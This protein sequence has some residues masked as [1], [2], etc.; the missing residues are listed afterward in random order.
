[1][2]WTAPQLPLGTGSTGI[3]CGQQPNAERGGT[4]WSTEDV[5]DREEGEWEEEPRDMEGCDEGGGGEEGRKIEGGEVGKNRQVGGCDVFFRMGDAGNAYLRS[6]LEAL[7]KQVL[8]T[9]ALD[10]VLV[11][12]CLCGLRRFAER[13]TAS[14]NTGSHLDISLRDHVL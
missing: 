13:F 4:P 7:E 12:C 2:L 11:I 6:D 5:Y 1:M 10:C 9:R 8:A 14:H 3:R